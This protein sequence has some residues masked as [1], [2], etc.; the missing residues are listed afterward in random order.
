MFVVGVVLGVLVARA[1]WSGKAT[2]WKAKAS[3]AIDDL[4]TA[5]K[6]LEGIL[7][8]RDTLLAEVEAG[9]QQWN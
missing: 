8:E 9:R 7:E 6:A 3:E 1:Y 5:E 4:D 2:F